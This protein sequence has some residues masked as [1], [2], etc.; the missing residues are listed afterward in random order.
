MGAYLDGEEQVGSVGSLLVDSVNGQPP[1]SESRELQAAYLSDLSGHVRLVKG[2]LAA[3]VPGGLVGAVT[4]PEDRATRAGV[5]LGDVVCLVSSQPAAEGPPPTWCARVV[6]LWR[7][8]DQADPY[9][10]VP[11][12]PIWFFTDRQDFF[13]LLNLAAQ[14]GASAERRYWP[15]AGSIAPADAGDVARR[16][17]AVRRAAGGD[18]VGPT[19]DRGLDRYAAGWRSAIPS[20][21]LLSAALVV[22]SIALGSV[23]G[24]QFLHARAADLALLRARG[25][26]ASRVRSLVLLE[27]AVVSAAALALAAGTAALAMLAAGGWGVWLPNLG[28]GQLLEIGAE[29]VIVL[30][31]IAVWL[32]LL[33][34]RVSRQYRVRGEA[35]GP[36]WLGVAWQPSGIAATLARRRLHRSGRRNA[37][38]G[39]LLVLAFAIAVFAAVDAAHMLLDGRAGRPPNPLRGGLAATFLVGFVGAVL[40]GVSAHGFGFVFAMRARAV[41]HAAMFLDGLPPQ[42]L[43][44]SLAIEQQ[45]VL[46]LALLAGAGLGIAAAWGASPPLSAA[47]AGIGVGMTAVLAAAGGMASTWLVRLAADRSAQSEVLNRV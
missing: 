6:G 33:A 2:E 42:V 38:A 7:P 17:R 5:A 10:S 41:D 29:L 44:H 15:A 47:A 11:G 18:A 1:A 9:W 16:V 21:E 22:L 34:G 31:G 30:A 32:A 26:P 8:L 13:A 12:S 19:L 28:R 39:L 43:R 40:A 36:G 24:R 3:G 35:D 14:T 46:G 23:L 27:L 4:M 25:W 37:W 20:V 45:V